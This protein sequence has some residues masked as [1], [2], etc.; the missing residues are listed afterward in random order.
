MVRL[1]A[2]GLAAELATI[3][4]RNWGRLYARAGQH[5]AVET[6]D[7]IAGGDPARCAQ[8]AK[9]LACSQFAA[10]IAARDPVWFAGFVAERG[11][12]RA[13]DDGRIAALLEHHGLAATA[14]LDGDLDALKSILRVL[15]NR[16]MVAVI[17]RDIN[18]QADLAETAGSMSRMADRLIDAALAVLH[19]W[20]VAT[21]G[22]PTG[23]ESAAPQQLVVIA[24]GKLGAGELNLSSDVDLVFAFPENGSTAGGRKTSQQFF[25]ALGQRLIQVLDAVTADGFVFR[26]DMRL[27]PFGDAGPLVFSF[28]AM[29]RYF[30]EHGRD[31]ERYAWIR[32]RPCAGD[33]EAGE[34]LIRTLQPFVFRRYLDFGAIAALR[35]MKSRIEAERRAARMAGDIKLGPGGIRDV[36]F[37]AQMLQL[38]WAGRHGRLR[39]RRI[40]ATYEA[41]A[42]LGLMAQETATALAAAY[43]FLRNLEHKLQAIAD[44]Q[45]QMLPDDAVDR[46]RVATMLGYGDPDALDHAL[47]VHRARVAREFAGLIGPVNAEP[48]DQTRWRE[49]WQENDEVALRQRVAAAGFDDVELVATQLVRLRRARD[50]P[51]VGSEGQSRLDELMPI[52]LA[53]AQSVAQ[54]DIAVARVVPLFEAI[55]RRSAY[56]VLLLENPQALTELVQICATSRWLSDEI[57]RHPGLLDELLD[58]NLLYTVADRETLRVALRERLQWVSDDDVEAQLEVL[59]KFKET[60]SFRVA[61]CELKG[62]LP[63]MNVSDYLT[64]LAEVILEQALAIAWQTT[65]GAPDPALGRP[66][67]IVGYGKLGGLELGPG[68]DLDLV[69]VHDLSDDHWHFLHRMVRRLLQVLTMRSHSGSLYAVDMRLRPSGNAGTLISSLAALERYQQQQAWTWEHQALVRARPVAGDPALASRFERVRANV[70]CAARD[71]DELKR[72]VLEMRRRIESASAGDAD[73]KR[74]AGGIVDIEFMVQYL[75]LGWAHEHPDLCRFTDNVRI[76]ETAASLHLLDDE[77]ARAL[78]DAYLALRAERHRTALDIADDERARQVLARYRERVRDCWNALFGE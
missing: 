66:F 11:Y 42:Q 32:A 37:I 38:I 59:R 65:E 41:L 54:P 45:T 40:D 6:L 62:I 26:V 56:F 44:R 16:L 70:L 1:P 67:I 46:Q 69:F 23:E 43:A 4:E 5:G 76:L 77:Q 29:E 28:E 78:K 17:W 18:G 9:L 10:D 55:M 48:P 35:E 75:V 13:L 36:E 53:A 52:L 27:R 24:L 7:H 34:Q 58:P 2:E 74:P 64:F 21:E 25:T 60:H 20:A 68:S 33:R 22:T 47:A 73:L 12:E 3:A 30:E 57:A 8:L 49:L 14:S 39:Q 61:A 71:R 15:R 19:R 31:W 50:R 51:W 63:L 72:N